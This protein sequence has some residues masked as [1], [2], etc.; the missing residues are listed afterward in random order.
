MCDRT[1]ITEAR[2]I[3][4]TYKGIPTATHITISA[5]AGRIRI[6]SVT[7]VPDLRAR[8]IRVSQWGAEYHK[9]TASNQN[10]N[11]KTLT[12]LTL[13]MKKAILALVLLASVITTDAQIP[14]YT[15]TRPNIFGQRT[16]TGPYGFSG[17]ID[18]PKIFGEQHFRYNNGVQ[19]YVTQ[20]NIFGEQHIYTMP[21]RYGW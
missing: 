18:R 17:T 9:R 13:T 1:T 14:S 6:T 5:S 3:K 20:P 10:N 12:R 19:G 8:S 2:F 7:N 4:G 16:I 21:R 15:I 11:V